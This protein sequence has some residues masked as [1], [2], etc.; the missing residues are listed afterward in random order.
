VQFLLLLLPGFAKIMHSLG[1]LLPLF[2]MYTNK[3]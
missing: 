1:D 2:S 3:E